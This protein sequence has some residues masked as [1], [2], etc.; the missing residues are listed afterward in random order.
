MGIG[1]VLF[2]ALLGTFLLAGGA[3][4]FF[5]VW[6]LIVAIVGG[7]SLLVIFGEPIALATGLASEATIAAAALR[8]AEKEKQKAQAASSTVHPT[9]TTV[10]KNTVPD[11]SDFYHQAMKEIHKQLAPIGRSSSALAMPAT[12]AMEIKDLYR[13]AKYVLFLGLI[14][15]LAYFV[16]GKAGLQTSF[17]IGILG[18]IIGLLL[19]HRFYLPGAQVIMKLLGVIAVAAGGLLV[20]LL[21]GRFA[22]PAML[23]TLALGVFVVIIFVEWKFKA[24]TVVLLVNALVFSILLGPP[25][26]LN[27]PPINAFSYDHLFRPESPLF[28]AAEAQSTIFQ[29][30]WA[31]FLN[32]PQKLKEGGTRAQQA[33]NKQMLI[34]TGDYETGVEAQSTAPLGVFLEHAGVTSPRV[35]IGTPIDMYAELTAQA[36]KSGEDVFKIQLRCYAKDLMGKEITGSKGEITQSTFELMELESYPIDCILDSTKIGQVAAKATLEATFDFTTSAFLKGHFM[37]QDVIRDYTRQEKQPLT[38][39]GISGKDLDAVYTAGPLRIGMGLGK[40]PVPIITNSPFA[41]TLGITFEN[42]WPQGTFVAFN[43]LTI[44]APPGINII[45][46]DGDGQSIAGKCKTN[47]RKEHV[48]TLFAQDA[49]RFFPDKIFTKTIRVQTQGRSTEELLGGAPLAIRS[50][51]V[52]VD[53]TYTIDTSVDITVIPAQTPTIPIQHI[54]VP[55]PP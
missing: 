50:F 9:Q 35:P 13:N 52:D 40:Q 54:G 34:A 17:N 21:L 28:L 30:G 42:N 10:I 11:I 22:L 6:G 2:T 5:G 33:L 37:P 4:Y 12:T 48:C 47:V 27:Y 31:K 23:T 49:A 7:I 29:Q 51:K 26:F 1:N 14:G 39:F 46:I 15:F 24:G 38:E 3:Y 53:Y 55:V 20:F 45:G 36:F 19:L 44:T 43:K 32:A 16:L 18:F 8:K 41:P 25:S